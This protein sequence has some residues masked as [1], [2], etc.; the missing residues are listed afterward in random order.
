MEHMIRKLSVEVTEE[1]LRWDQRNLR[2][3]PVCL[4]EAKLGQGFKLRQTLVSSSAQGG[5]CSYF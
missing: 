4:L 3:G 2:S 5:H 1:S